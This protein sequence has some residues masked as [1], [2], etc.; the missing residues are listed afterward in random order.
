MRHTHELEPTVRPPIMNVFKRFD[1]SHWPFTRLDS[2]GAGVGISDVDHL[3]QK[4]HQQHHHHY[5]PPAVAVSSISGV[6]PLPEETQWKAS[7][8]TRRA[9]A[10]VSS[11]R[12]SPSPSAIRHGVHP[13]HQVLFTSQTA[14]AQAVAPQAAVADAVASALP[15]MLA[16]S[17]LPAA[18]GDDRMQR[19]LRQGKTA[20]ED[21]TPQPCRTRGK[22]VN[23]FPRLGDDEFT[24]KPPLNVQAPAAGPVQVPYHQRVV[25]LGNPTRVPGT[26]GTEPNCCLLPVSNPTEARLDKLCPAVAVTMAPTW[27]PIFCTAWVPTVCTAERVPA[28][29]TS[30]RQQPQPQPAAQQRPTG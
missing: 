15:G 6:T 2:S 21:V 26:L 22:C 1:C 20:A 30:A 5:H 17:A 14:T 7:S 13:E 12:S 10:Q 19:P 25:D 28:Y 27:V 11:S 4:Q 3:Q 29:Q 9:A 24:N 18:P 8:L 16:S 23:F